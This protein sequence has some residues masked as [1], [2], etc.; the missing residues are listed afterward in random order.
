MKPLKRA[1]ATHRG[2]VAV[3]V[4]VMVL[5]TVAGGALAW[6]LLAGTEALLDG[7]LP[8]T[9]KA[10]SPTA[11]APQ[12][13]S[14]PVPEATDSCHP[15]PQTSNPEGCHEPLPGESTGADPAGPWWVMLLL[16]AGLGL[17][18]YAASGR[19]R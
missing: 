1:R 16:P 3:S 15:S 14:G 4:A 9:G 5:L 13:E 11:T 6:A 2:R 12:G 7:A 10:F 18:V 8:H 17:L 19:R